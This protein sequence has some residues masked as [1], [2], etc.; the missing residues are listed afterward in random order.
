[1]D[2]NIGCLGFLLI[3]VLCLLCSYWLFNAVM[4]S[5]LPDWIKYMILR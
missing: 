3:L 2:D 1:M 4:N 5:N